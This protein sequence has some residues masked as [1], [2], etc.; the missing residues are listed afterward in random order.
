MSLELIYTSAPRGLNS[1]VSGFCA[2]AATGGM[3]RQVQ[4]TLEGLSGYQFHFNLSDPSADRNPVN[5]AH[6]RVRIGGEMRSVLSRIA[7]AGADYSGRTNKIAHHVLLER[8]EQLP[9]GPAWMMMAM[10]SGVFVAGW[11]AEPKHLDKRSMASILSNEPR[12]PEP[13]TTWEAVTGDTGW[14]GALA[15]AFRTN[16]KVPAYVVFEPG[17]ELL[18]LFEESLALLP[19]EERW[20]VAFATYYTTLPAGCH[21]HWRGVVAGSRAAQEVRRFPNATVIDLTSALGPAADSP[22]TEAARTGQVLPP[23]EAARPQPKVRIR[24]RRRTPTR[25][26]VAAGIGAEATPPIAED[27]PSDAMLPDFVPGSPP[28]RRPVGR[29]SRTVAALIT[30]IAILGAALAASLIGNILLSR[31]LQEA[32]HLGAALAASLIGNVM[33]SRALHEKS[34]TSP[35][36]APAGE[37]PAGE[38]PAGEAPAGEAPAGEAPA[39][40]APASEAPA[41]EAPAGEAPAGEAPAGEAPTGEAPA[42]EAPAGEAPAGE[43]PA[44]E[45]PAGEA[46]RVAKYFL[47]REEHLEGAGQD[48]NPPPVAPRKDNSEYVFTLGHGRDLAFLDVPQRVR[49]PSVGLHSATLEGNSAKKEVT[50]LVVQS[51]TGLETTFGLKIADDGLRI[52]ANPEFLMTCRFARKGKNTEMRCRIE[53]GLQQNYPWQGLVLEV[54]E[55]NGTLYQCDFG[56]EQRKVFIFTVGYNK[57]GKLLKNKSESVLCP[58]P[59]ILQF[60][61]GNKEPSPLFVGKGGLAR[62]IAL[63]ARRDLSDGEKSLG[64]M[65]LHGAKIVV[66]CPP[67]SGGSDTLNVSVDMGTSFATITEEVNGQIGPWKEAKAELHRLKDKSN[68]EAEQ[69][70]GKQSGKLNHC[71]A[72]IRRRLGTMKEMLEENSPIELLDPWGIPAAAIK[73]QFRGSAE[74]LINAADKGQ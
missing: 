16:P 32:R 23:R 47:P 62:D 43:A 44:G 22:F 50:S 70:K 59:R 34:P 38:A 6:T 52:T 73:I 48:N 30:T 31:A 67:G 58:W 66:T 68:A 51:S 18:P 33:L 29:R 5:F 21:Y 56:A 60:S 27:V 19:P 42:G 54:K 28:P 37:A 10:A 57:A 45:A 11:E 69:E 14:G 9:G 2:V 53:G 46:I 17:Q 3:S 12:P 25:E 15:Q 26:E 36:E 40:E 39:G 65:S 41:G 64:S 72:Q 7:F 61:V 8:G 1:T 55:E 49:G 74:D 4:A 71:L 35:G 24:D 20:Q 13:A 63:E